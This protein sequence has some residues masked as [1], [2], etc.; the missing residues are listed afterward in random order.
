MPRLFAVVVGMLFAGCLNSAVVAQDQPKEGEAKPKVEPVDFRKLKELIPAEV[1]GLKRTRNE[2]QKLK[3][4]EFSMSNAEA[5]FE[6]PPPEEANETG[7]AN[8][9]APAPPRV[10][11]NI[12]DYAATQGGAGLAA[13]WAT[14]E[15][16]QETDNGYQKTVKVAGQPGFETWD[17]EGKSGT[18]QISVAERF[19]VTVNT[20]GLPAEKMQEI[21]KALQIEKLAKLK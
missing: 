16:D 12:T 15:I 1:A 3:L 4:G 21:A 6:N 8:A 9:D 17:G 18:L 20:T 19:I 11:V 5:T 10:E 14:S 2:G 13:V 7:D